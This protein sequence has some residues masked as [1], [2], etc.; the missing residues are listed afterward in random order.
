MN[1]RGLAGRAP[2]LWRRFV[3][4]GKRPGVPDPPARFELRARRS[5]ALAAA[6]LLQVGARWE[7][8]QRSHEGSRDPESVVQDQQD[9]D[10][11]RPFNAPR[12]I[13]TPTVQTDHKALNLAQWLTVLSYRRRHT[14]CFRDHGRSGPPGQDVCCHGVVTRFSIGPCTTTTGFAECWTTALETLPRSA[15]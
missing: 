11:C 5:V 13:R 10:I 1:A 9:S 4:T 8:P 15:D 3:I 6:E 14:H 12:E 2:Q 7:H